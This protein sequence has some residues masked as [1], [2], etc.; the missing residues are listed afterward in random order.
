LLRAA[1]RKLLQHPQPPRCLTRNAEEG[2]PVTPK[3]AA[4]ENGGTALEGFEVL[5]AAVDAVDEGDSA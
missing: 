5:L 1:L 4:A 2:N 3:S